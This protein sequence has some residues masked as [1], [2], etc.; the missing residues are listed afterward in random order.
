MSA[1]VRAGENRALAGDTESFRAPEPEIEPAIAFPETNL[2]SWAPAKAGGLKP[3][4]SP[5]LPGK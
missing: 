2:I 1:V 3:E 5:V 4:R